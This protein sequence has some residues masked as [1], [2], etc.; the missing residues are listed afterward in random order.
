VGEA[1]G[2]R[3]VSRRALLMGAAMLGLDGLGPWPRARAGATPGSSGQG[4]GVEVSVAPSRPQPGDVLLFRVT[5]GPPDVRVEWD[6]RAVSVFPS[7]SRRVALI[8]IDL[9]TRPGA[10]GWRVTRPSATKNGGALAAGVVTV[11]S[12]T[13]PTQQLT[14]PKGMVDLDAATLARVETERGELKAALADG[15]SERLWRG[16]FRAPVEGGQP[17]GGFG[18]RRIINGQPRSPHTGFDWAA[19]VGTPVLATNAGRAALVAEH[20]FAG[21]NV[22]LDHGLGLFTFY[23]HLDET[24]VGAGEPVVAGQ[25]IGAVG[26][27]GRV[28]GPHLHFGVLLGGA[29]VDPEALLALTPPPERPLP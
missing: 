15:A 1:P 21:R 13:F 6:G 7:G 20:F 24:R 22:V 23:Y 19:P 4:G 10:I 11:R 9:D 17:T 8:G 5:G 29:R 18:L 14:L 2:A 3:P 12:R 26:A 25:V 28:T 27:T 16:P